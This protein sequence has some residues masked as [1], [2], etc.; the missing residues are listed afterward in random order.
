MQ[1]TTEKENL[2]LLCKDAI[3]SPFTWV[4]EH[5][6]T[7]YTAPS[8]LSLPNYWCNMCWNKLYTHTSFLGVNV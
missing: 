7:V 6:R 4:G 1:T 5:S 2:K 3:F 8:F